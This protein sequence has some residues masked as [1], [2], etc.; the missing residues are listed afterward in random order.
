MGVGFFG[1]NSIATLAA[2]SYERYRVIKA[3]AYRPAVAK[4]RI[5]RCRAQMVNL[6]ITYFKNYLYLYMLTTLVLLFVSD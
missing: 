2:I 6:F 1:L 4:W 3:S 5:T